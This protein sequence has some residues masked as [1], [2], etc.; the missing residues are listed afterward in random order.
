MERLR[1]FLSVPLD[2]VLHPASDSAQQVAAE[3]KDKVAMAL[4]DKQ[5]KLAEVQHNLDG[6]A[7]P[8]H[9]LSRR[10]TCRY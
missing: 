2:T 1:K 3:Q 10:P 5:R 9:A 6:P 4:E 7:S 8:N